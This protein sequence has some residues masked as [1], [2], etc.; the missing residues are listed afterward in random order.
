MI[1]NTVGY[2][3]EPDK[4]KIPEINPSEIIM[5]REIGDGWYMYKTT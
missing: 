4:T 5:I 2:F 1:D 3:Y